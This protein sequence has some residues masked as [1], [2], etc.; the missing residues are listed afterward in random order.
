MG[1]AIIKNLS[2]F[3]RIVYPKGYLYMENTGSNYL[4]SV[5]KLFRYYKSLGDKAIEQIN[6]EQ[7]HWQYNQESNSIA[8][9]IKHIAG[10]SLSRWS[11]FLTTDG[12][13]EWRNRDDEFEET[14]STK[15]ELIALWDKGWQCIY[16][17]I[18]PLADDDLMRIVYIRNEGHTVVEAIN[19]QL[20]H[21]PYHVGQIVFAAKMIAAQN[22]SSLSIPK[23]QSKT[24]NAD[25]FSNEKQRKFFT[26]G[27]DEK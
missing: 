2:K 12:E 10:N 13:K 11:D 3:V 17:A 6:E 1:L 15:E 14:A 18:D 16:K 20:A 19:R 22:W 24:F 21:I 25:K 7:M 5:K 8:I 9:I 4:S 26:K 23:G 27:T